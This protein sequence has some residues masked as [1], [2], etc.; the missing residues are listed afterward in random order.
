MGQFCSLAADK[1]YFYILRLHLLEALAWENKTAQ[2]NLEEPV[3]LNKAVSQDSLAVGV[4]PTGNG[5]R[6]C[7]CQRCQRHQESYSVTAVSGRM[8]HTITFF[9]N[10]GKT[11]SN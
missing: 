2:N 5:S 1:S 10:L 4:W 11:V 8:G 7:P 6:A 9:L 3:L